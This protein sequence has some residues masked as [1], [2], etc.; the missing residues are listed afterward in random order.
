M[1]DDAA[2]TEPEA[3][4]PFRW[5][6]LIKPT[7]TVVVFAAFAYGLR[8][9]LATFDYDEVVAG[10]DQ[11]APARIVVAALVVV[12]IHG[13]YV[14]RERIAV[15]FAGHAA[16]ATRKVALASLISRSLST[17]GVAT[18]TGFALRLRLYQ[19]FG[20]D[21]RAVGRITAYN[22]AS[23]YVG[24]GASLGLALTV[25]GLPP[26]VASSYALPPLGW[27]GPVAAVLVLAYLGWNLR[28]RAPLYVR[29]FEVPLLTRPQLA[30]QIV[31]PV[32]DTL[33][34]GYVTYVLLPPIGLSYLEV[35]AIGLAA[36]VA[37]S[38]SQ[39]PG[40]LGVYET[41]VL[42][43]VP[44][45]A[46][47]TALAA[48]LVRRAVVNLLPIAA[49]AVLLVGVSMTS[50]LTRRPS[51]V[52][53]DYGRDAVAIATFA[54]SVLSLIAAAV[55]RAHGLTDRLGPLAQVAVFA[56]GLAT[57][58]AARGL[59]QGRRRAW[60]VCV[61]LFGLRLGAAIVGGP[62]VPSLIIAGA[63]L[64]VL[65]VGYHLFKHPG[66]L[67]DGERTWWT[68]WLVALIGIAWVADA[69]PATLTTE[70]R[71]RLA[72]VIVVAAVVLGATIR[73]ALPERRRRRRARGR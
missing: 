29:S 10:L 69:H 72:G 8:S 54:A 60:W 57:L 24:L 48:L 49:G 37:G 5:R 12:A 7:L 44:P 25:A 43:F 52:A 19:D 50:Q 35:V 59:Q 14:V 39:V 64:A 11:V 4:P 31:L 3:A 67:F 65:L 61:V 23:Y 53:L 20:L 42:A 38:L 70:V 28:R 34:T 36:S 27:I 2:M 30:A 15:D 73:R 46:H 6:R 56:G 51:R 63:M 47:P 41:T 55:P 18:V 9:L 71:A 16:L 1:I 58:V 32:L 21:A 66:P 45:A 22:E 17:L 13:L 68:A 40:G 62:H 26:V 33:A